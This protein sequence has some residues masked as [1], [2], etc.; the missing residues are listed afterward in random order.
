MPQFP[1]SRLIKTNKKLLAW[2]VFRLSNEAADIQRTVQGFE[3]CRIITETIPTYLAQ[4]ILIYDSK[5]SR[6]CTNRNVYAST[7]RFNMLF[8]LN[9]VFLTLDLRIPKLLSSLWLNHL[10]ALYPLTNGQLSNF[11]ATWAPQ[12]LLPRYKWIPNVQLSL[13]LDK[14]QLYI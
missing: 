14:R 5:K 12:A 2:F 11:Q 8:C 6:K 7:E 13:L 4:D 3:Y 10:F 9:I 1:L